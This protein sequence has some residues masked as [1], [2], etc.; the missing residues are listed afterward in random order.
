MYA[1]G[2]DFDADPALP[3]AGETLR[4]TLL[5]APTKLGLLAQR[6]REALVARK[7]ARGEAR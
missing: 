4:D 3:W 1:L 7:R 5:E 6:T 2:F